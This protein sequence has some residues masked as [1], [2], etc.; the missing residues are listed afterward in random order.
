ME[1]L[2]SSCLRYPRNNSGHAPGYNRAGFAWLQLISYT[3]RKEE[4]N[5]R[6]ERT[7][8]QQAAAECK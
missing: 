7:E 3:K 6:A 2:S 8:E 4:E 1:L 5:V